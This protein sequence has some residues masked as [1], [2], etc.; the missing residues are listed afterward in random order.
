MNF[1]K[2]L[3]AASG[4][5]LS[6]PFDVEFIWTNHYWSSELRKDCYILDLLIM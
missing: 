3:K 4:E 5:K 1:V 6:L 2:L